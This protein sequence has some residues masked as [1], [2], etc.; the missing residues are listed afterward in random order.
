L[1]SLVLPKDIKVKIYRNII[2][3]VPYVDGKER[4]QNVQEPCA[5]KNVWTRRLSENS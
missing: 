2:L 4:I 3:P 1:L 5:E